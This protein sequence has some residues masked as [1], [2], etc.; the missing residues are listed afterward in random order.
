MA[1]RMLDLPIGGIDDMAI[2]TGFVWE[3]VA[4][5]I[6]SGPPN[7]PMPRMSAEVSGNDDQSGDWMRRFI[8]LARAE[9]ALVNRERV[10]QLLRSSAASDMQPPFVW[11]HGSSGLVYRGAPEAEDVMRAALAALV[12]A[13]GVPLPTT[14]SIP[15]PAAGA[16]VPRAEGLVLAARIDSLSPV[17]YLGSSVAVGDFD[18]DGTCLYDS[19]AV[20]EFPLL[21]LLFLD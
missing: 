2:W 20:S 14:G 11:D 3:R 6:D 21:E 13:T 4:R 12:E 5:W 15:A 1:E 10:A 17:S 18:G 16:V 7:D 8:R 9:P 19:L